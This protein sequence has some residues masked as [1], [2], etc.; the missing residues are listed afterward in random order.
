MPRGFSL[1]EVLLAL[2]L[3]AVTS[4]L[5]GTL[6]LED[7]GS[8]M[9]NRE[10]SDALLLTQEGLEVA[11]LL[12][13]QGWDQVPAGTHG[14]AF[15]GNQW[16]LAGQQELNGIYTRELVVADR[17]ANHKSVSSRVSW[18]D[19]R[20]GQQRNVALDTEL[21][22]FQ[23]PTT[24]ATAV[25]MDLSGVSIAGSGQN[26]VR[27]IV[28]Q[29]TQTFPVT[30]THTQWTWS[31]TKEIRRL[32]IESG[33]SNAVVWDKDGPGTPEEEQPSGTTL[34]IVDVGIAPGTAATVTQ[35]QFTGKIAG[36]SMSAVLTF[37]DG[38]TKVVPTFNP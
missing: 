28:L 19:P 29:N 3:F 36:V 35:M 4:V 15:S 20:S 1:L 11:R 22:N 17:D 27:N 10:R 2:G 16:T 33:G 31:N 7:A 37:A 18:T 12:R 26:E 13:D 32:R 25:I 9:R 6:V 38:S 30:L 34:N 8:T 24:Q 23:N 21:A 5:F 14:L